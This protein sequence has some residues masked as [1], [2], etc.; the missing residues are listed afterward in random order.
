MEASV[1]SC[2]PSCAELLAVEHKALLLEQRG[3]TL[4]GHDD[5]LCL[6]LVMIGLHMCQPEITLAYA[7]NPGTQL[8]IRHALV[9][10]LQVSY[11][12]VVGHLR[13]C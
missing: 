13:H 4:I 6:I 1:G 8:C 3:M 5:P 12:V 10:A 2:L 7:L 11:M 9:R